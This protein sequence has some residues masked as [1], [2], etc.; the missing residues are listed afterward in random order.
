MVPFGEGEAFCL[1]EVV[2]FNKGEACCWL[3]GVVPFGK[4]EV[5]LLGKGTGS[6]AASFWKESINFR[7]QAVAR[8]ALGLVTLTFTDDPEMHSHIDQFIRQARGW[9][10]QVVSHIVASSVRWHESF[11][12]GWLMLFANQLVWYM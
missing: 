9:S 3:A 11:A 10:H 2:P 5:A 6:V 7:F 12:I 1:R 4:G 8:G